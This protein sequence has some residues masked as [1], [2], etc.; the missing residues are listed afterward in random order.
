MI[1]NTKS[2]VSLSHT[3]ANTY[4]KKFDMN[5]SQMNHSYTLLTP[6]KT[7]F[8]EQCLYKNNDIISSHK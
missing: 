2:V 5:E 4:R 8:S 6:P 1:A 7:T 3:H